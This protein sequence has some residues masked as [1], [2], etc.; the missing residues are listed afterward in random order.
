MDI[1]EFLQFPFMQRALIAGILL[2]VLLASLGIFV[3]LRRMAFFG[4][5]IAHASLA[6][7]AIAVLA[8]LNPLPVAIVW[9]IILAFLIFVLEQKTKLP[10]DTVIGIFF[11][12]AMALG[13]VL[14][15]F[16]TG[17]QPELMSFLFG[18]ILSVSFADLITIAISTIVIITWLIFSRRQITFLSLSEEQAIVSGVPVRLQ[19]AALYVALAIATV[20]GVKILGIIL[21]SALLII[22]PAISRLHA[23]SFRSH[24]ILAVLFSEI[25]IVLGLALS[26]FFDLPSG[27]T[28]ILVGAF[29]F[30]FLLL[31]SSQ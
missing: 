31:F 14:M 7:I 30:L 8:G 1:L 15:N 19:T 18:S 9:S 3:T 13:V 25:I 28:I 12:S 2:G 6:G 16:T 23:K 22:P 4:E 10:I 5:G 20:L 26:F 21:V 27:A 17:Y 11:T 24:L 29:L